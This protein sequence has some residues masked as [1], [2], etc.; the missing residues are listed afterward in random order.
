MG[1]RENFGNLFAF[2]PNFVRRTSLG[3]YP[4]AT[5][6]VPEA[7]NWYLLI[8]NRFIFESSVLVGM[9]SFA[10]APV[11]PE[12]RPLLAAS[13]ASIISFSVLYRTPLSVNAGLAA[14]WEEGRLSQVSST[15]K[16]SPSLKMTARSI[17]L[18]SSRTLPG[19]LYAWKSLRVL[20]SINLNFLPA[21]FP[22][23]PMKYSTSKG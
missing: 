21:F 8:P 9:P 1:K 12:T 15:E 19:Q 4:Y 13:A 14:V 20:S 10:A 22:M 11:G 17:T 16:M 6:S 23:R 2:G 18:C 5:G 7:L 3:V